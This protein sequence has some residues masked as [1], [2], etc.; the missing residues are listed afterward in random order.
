L[1][2]LCI[3]MSGLGF[4]TRLKGFGNCPGPLTFLHHDLHIVDPQ[5]IADSSVEGLAAA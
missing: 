1:K 3:Y 2:L 4:S 5:G